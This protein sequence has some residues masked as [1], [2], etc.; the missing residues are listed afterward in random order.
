MRARTCSR[1]AWC[2][3]RWRRAC[4]RSAARRRGPC[5]SEILTQGADR[6]GAAQSGGAGRPR[7]DRQQA[8]REGPRAAL[9]VGG[10]PARGP[11]ATPT[12]AGPARAG[13]PRRAEQASIV[14]LPFENLSPDPDN[15]YFADG[16]TEEVIADLSKVRALR[17]ISRTSAMHYKGTTKPLPT[18]A[19]E[20][21]VRH[22]LEGSVRRAGQ[23]PAHHGA[24]H[25]RRDRRAPLGGEVQRHARRCVRPPGAVVAPAI[26][27]A[28]KVALSARRRADGWRRAAARRR[29][30]LRVLPARAARPATDDQGRMG[31]W[32]SDATAGPRRLRRQ[33]RAPCR[34]RP[35]VPLRAGSRF[36]EPREDGL[37]AIRAAV[38]RV[39][40]HGAEAMLTSRA[41]L[42][43][44]DGNHVRSMRFFEDAVV[45]NPSD[46]DALFWLSVAYLGVE[47]SRQPAWRPR[48]AWSMSTL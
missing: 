36:L 4:R 34:H 12:R 45:H 18:I 40:E 37:A 19:R 5:S 2:C 7:A 16:L 42:E 31:A 41:W 46:T 6:A 28:L 44:I 43:R 9:P 38:A 17:V 21:N 32:A 35:G 15:A 30:R 8:A 25:R 26:V 48:T 1:W 47:A 23:Q 39:G 29:P 14:V 33:R 27:E 24:A 20:L 3:T 11:R 10:R 22:V 13:R